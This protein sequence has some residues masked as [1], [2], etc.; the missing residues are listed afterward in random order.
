MLQGIEQ[1]FDNITEMITGLKRTTYQEKFETFQAE[2][3]YYFEE[4]SAYMKETENHEAAAEAAEQEFINRFQKGAMPDEMPEFTFE[5]EIGL[6]TLLK[7][8]GLVPS[9]SE[10]IRS[11]KQGGVKINGEKVEDMKANAPKGTNVYQV[12]KRKFARVTIA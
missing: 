1:I 12:G 10:A 6:A 2:Y 5:G 7:E 9:T 3:G 4:M 8:A 11:A